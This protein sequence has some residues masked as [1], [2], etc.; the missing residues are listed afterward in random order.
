MLPGGR[1]TVCTEE[2]DLS[3][4]NSLRDVD[5]SV[6]E[7]RRY[8]G[9]DVSML[10]RWTPLPLRGGE[11]DAGLLIGGGWMEMDEIESIG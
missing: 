9:V 3:C 7:H 8:F 2:E 4:S 11:E 10:C 1:Y 5:F 6:K